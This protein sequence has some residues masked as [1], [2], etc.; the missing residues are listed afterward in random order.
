[1]IYTI[2]K[3]QCGFFFLTPKIDFLCDNFRGRYLGFGCMQMTA[4]CMWRELSWSFSQYS[5]PCKFYKELPTQCK[6][7][8]WKS[9][10]LKRTL[11]NACAYVCVCVHVMC[12]YQYFEMNVD[13]DTCSAFLH[14]QLHLF[15]KSIFWIL[16]R[17]R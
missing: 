2:G 3:V 17:L 15:L 10:E 11:K 16:Y 12:I 8:M 7:C 4:K 13:S 14:I 9:F 6:F 1:M 5:G